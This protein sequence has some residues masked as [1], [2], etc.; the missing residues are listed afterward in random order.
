MKTLIAYIIFISVA[1]SFS[2]Q[3]NSQIIQ[4]EW[5]DHLSYTFNYHIADAGNIIYSA[6]Q[7]GMLSYNKETGEIQKHSKVTGL[8]D[9]EL[10]TIA[11]SKLTNK[12]ILGYLNGNID[13]IDLDD[14]SLSNIADIKRKSISGNK[15][16]N[17]IY[18]YN[19]FAYLSCSFGIVVLDINKEEIKDSYLFGEGGTTI[20]VNDISIINNFLYAA[21]ESGIYFA[22]LDSPNLVDY[23]YWSRINFIPQSTS[24]YSIVEY[25]ENK[26]YAVYHE[27]IADK[28]IIINI[29]N[30]AYQEWNGQYDEI[31]NN[32][33]SSNG[34]FSISG[35][36]RGLVYSPGGNLYLDFTSYAINHIFV[37]SESNVFVA[38]MV[39][40]FT[41]Q[42]N[43]TKTKF[44][45]VNGPRFREVSK[46]EAKGDHIWVSSG[47]PEN[48]YKH[49]A[50]Y[51][52]IEN[53]WSS[54]TANDIPTT[55]AFGNTYK[56]AIDPK[57][58]NHVFAAAFMYGIIEFRDGEVVDV[59]EKDDLEIFSDIEDI[60]D[61]RTVGIQ[62]DN[63]GNL[64]ILLG[65]VTSPLVILDNEG[66]WKRPQI[67]NAVLNNKKV[68]YSDLL[69]TSAGQIWISTKGHGIVVLEEDGSGN[70][71]SNSF[72][73][74]NQDKKTIS[75]AYCLN[76]DNEGDIWVGTNSG[77][78][79]YHSPSYIISESDVRGHQ[80][81]IPRNDG[82]GS[83]DYLLS[84]ELILD[85][86][87]DGG[88]RKWFATASS[89][90]FLISENGKT[91]IHNFRDNN[92]P[93]FSNSVSGIGI[94]EKDGEVFFATSL[95]LLSYKGSA[96]KGFSEYTDVYVYPNPVRPD[97]NGIITI[98]G[99]VENSVVK[100][101][102]ISGNIVYETSSLG[103]QAIW[104]GKNFKGNRVA[105]GVYLVFLA[106]EDGEK[107]HMTKLLFLH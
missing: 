70:F 49:G 53:K 41:I 60:I 98:T 106:T 21:T 44:L 66:N 82:T 74:V 67:S 68:N 83:G 51:S 29:E 17:S 19:E 103:G 28:D 45:S 18:I 32:I 72:Q 88:N 58:Y 85:I 89:G 8:S 12:L 26:L 56:F 16:I 91:T 15:N 52:F 93:L 35:N 75:K 4:G 64:Y 25:H 13:I 43:N 94:N 59:I 47:G 92:S 34:Y 63:R 50:A 3:I 20:L 96:T 76:E 107:S 99:L 79:I 37:D 65:L 77:P 46:V 73:I 55:K 42:Q 101:T 80:I 11:Y 78:I 14:G 48:I 33:T 2:E 5:R 90:V 104:D 9:I 30:N 39:S 24:A 69:V 71:Y 100:I 22:D 23:N 36:N 27:T 40:G 95:G 97:Y 81:K 54:Y 105:S 1:I 31:V 7:S 38:G 10:S 84:G 61:L 87:T 57:D 86:K 6:A 102:D 62:Y